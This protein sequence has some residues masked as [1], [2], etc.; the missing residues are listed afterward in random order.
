MF[1]WRARRQ[2]IALMIPVTIIGIILVLNF[3][4]I[5]PVSTCFDG[6]QNQGETETDCGGP[7]SSCEIKHPQSITIFWTKFLQTREGSFDLAAYIQNPNETIS[8]SGLEYEFVLFDDLGVVA[9]RAGK[10]FIYPRERIHLVEAGIQTTRKPTYAEL[11]I[12]KTPWNSENINLPVLTVDEKNYKI[13]EQDG[14]QGSVETTISNRSSFG[15][16]EAELVFV[17]LDKNENLIGVNRS[18]LEDFLPRSSRSLRSTWP[19]KLDK[20]ARII[21]E[22]RINLFKTSAILQP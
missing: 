22:P 10:T 19:E 16:R 18:L 2:I 4:K 7:C 1:S 14:G 5:V 21:I 13:L 15:F 8:S 6:R 20:P 11:K 17:L 9:Y 3:R 12:T